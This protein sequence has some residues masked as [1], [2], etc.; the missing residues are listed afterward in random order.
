LLFI[1]VGHFNTIS[2]AQAGCEAHLIRPGIILLVIHQPDS[3]RF[4]DGGQDGV[5]LLQCSP[6]FVTITWKGERCMPP[7]LLHELES[8]SSSHAPQLVVSLALCGIVLLIVPDDRLAILAFL[9]Q[10]LVVIGLLWS[11][12]QLPLGS[13][14]IV[15]SIAIV[16]IYAVAELRLLLV[17][18][19]QRRQAG[20]GRPAT[21]SL[22]F[23]ALAATLGLLFTYGL[24]RVYAPGFFPPIVAYPVVLLTVN[25]F[26]IV[27]LANSALRTGMGILTFASGCRILYALWQPNLLVWGLWNACDV[28]VA[29]AASHLRSTEVAVLKSHAAGGPE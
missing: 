1:G 27:L 9:A 18:A 8:L 24:V 29:L 3:I 22:P 4:V 26:L 20:R 21:T 23:R 17:G 14:S 5:V 25:S 16:L 6:F 19:K 13:T 2:P 7:T 12:I 15:A 28:L 11:T 10:R